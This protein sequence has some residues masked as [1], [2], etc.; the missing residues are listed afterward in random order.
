M[1]NLEMMKNYI[2]EHGL[3]GQVRELVDGLGLSSADAVE[4]VYDV[5]TL[6]RDA[7]V[8]KYFG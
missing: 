7:F 5:H 6:S 4:H 3:I 2:R 1:T 8:A